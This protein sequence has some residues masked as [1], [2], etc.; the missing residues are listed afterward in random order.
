M[1]Y[2]KL[3]TLSVEHDYFDSGLWPAPVFVPTAAGAKALRR[4]RAE[5]RTR[6][7]VTTVY[8][9]VDEAGEPKV[10]FPEA[11]SIE[12]VWK[13]WPANVGRFTDLTAWMARRPVRLVNQ[14]P[15]PGDFISSEV[16]LDVVRD[17]E[18]VNE[19][20]VVGSPSSAEELPLKGRPAPGSSVASIVSSGPAI[21][22]YLPSNNL[23]VVNTRGWSKGDEFTVQYDQ[24]RG[25]PPSAQAI[26]EIRGISSAWLQTAPVRVIFSFKARSAYWVYYV[27]TNG[28]P[29]DPPFRIIDPRDPVRPPFPE[30]R[31]RDLVAAPD[32][33]DPV[34]A[35]LAESFPTLRRLRY[36]S[37]NLFT[38]KESPGVRF[39]LQRG[40]E[41]IFRALPLPTI[42]NAS[43]I[44][45]PAV[46][47]NNK[48]D[49]N[50]Q[51]IHWVANAG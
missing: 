14:A 12:L 3:L 51:I 45:D 34:A 49:T 43:W 26:V 20:F 21:T 42:E 47:Q 25:L 19:N 23:I 27:V 41:R 32:S 44:Y 24:M 8:V 50:Y 36:L 6:G 4:L 28:R 29:S 35:S 22:D 2:Q 31:V 18:R 39:Q 11:T 7:A 5:I 46:G 37:A 1:K 13:N 9:P 10:P 15:A 38:C 48:L 17:T 33:S 30:D 16:A 40:N